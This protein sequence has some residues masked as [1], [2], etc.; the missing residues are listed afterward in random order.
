M[1]AIA[2][3]RAGRRELFLEAFQD[4]R[5]QH[6]SDALKRMDRALAAYLK[7]L[8]I[9]PPDAQQ[10][11]TFFYFPG[12]P[13]LPY[14]D[15]ALQPWAGKLREAFP[16]IRAEALSV[17]HESQRALP[18][19]IQVKSPSAQGKYLG[20]AAANPTWQ[21]YFFYRHGKRYDDNH[22]RCPSTS[23]ALESLDLCRIAEQAPEICF[24]VLRPQTLIKP[25]RGVTNTRLVM[26][27][28]LLVPPH[29]ALNV[30]DRG[31][32]EWRE[33]ELVMFDD[34]FLHEAWNRSDTTRVILLM[35]CWNP[36]LTAVERLAC[37]QFIERVSSLKPAGAQ[38]EDAD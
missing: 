16:A 38:I 25:H 2:R 26:H 4:L 33:G 29:C 22:A 12:L 9:A 21:A 31:I 23:S 18:D 36:H 3:V 17:L 20:G 1:Q 10:R 13:D 32:H 28:P 6:G 34:T 30:V 11:P 19:F 5:V 7:E 15:P 35:D 14:H 8:D 37:R 27:L 24:S